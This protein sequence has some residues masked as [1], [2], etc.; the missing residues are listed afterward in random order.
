[1]RFS[2][3]F[4]GL[5]LTLVVSSLLPTGIAQATPVGPTVI[6]PDETACAR[7][8]TGDIRALTACGAGYTEEWLAHNG[9][10]GVVEHTVLLPNN[11]V[12]IH[13]SRTGSVC[14]YI[15]VTVFSLGLHHCDGITYVSA[16]HDAK[17]ILNP[18]EAI[19]AFVHES[20]HAMQERA[21]LDPVLAT[22]RNPRGPQLFPCEQS[23]DCW[24]G[25]AYRWFAARRDAYADI[26]TATKL[27][28]R[29]GVVGDRGH[30]SPAQRVSAFKLGLEQ[31]SGACNVYFNRYVFPGS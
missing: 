20:G 7:A 19:A 17:R 4:F 22:L 3:L 31:G 6:S 23:S 15:E 16:T 8:T 5:L 21:G 26:A 18:A 10:G 28:E 25:A 24:A 27:F 30:G 11:V 12:D 13:P 14:G 29:I 9:V 1:M 2:K